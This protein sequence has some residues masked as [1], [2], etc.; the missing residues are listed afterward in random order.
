MHDSRLRLDSSRHAQEGGGAPEGYRIRIENLV[1]GVGGKILEYEYD[2]KSGDLSSIL[3][4]AP[5]A[6]Y[7]AL[8]KDIGRLGP[9]LIPP[10]A[11]PRK[12][13]ETVSIRIRFKA[14]SR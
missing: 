12:G 4:E 5:L 11:S 10:K 3:V 1:K 6:R 7:D 2:E 9:S 13:R 8:L 14:S